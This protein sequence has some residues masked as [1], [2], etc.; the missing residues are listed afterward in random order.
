MEDELRNSLEEEAKSS[1]RSLNA[2][3][4]ARLKDDHTQNQREQGFKEGAYYAAGIL[5]N[6]LRTE[7]NFE[8]DE[9]LK[10]TESIQGLTPPPIDEEGIL[11]FFELQKEGDPDNELPWPPEDVA[12]AVF[13][14]I[15]NPELVEKATTNTKKRNKKPPRFIGDKR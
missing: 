5:A 8:S 13:R 9:C 1:G 2:E 14:F 3:I 7:Y 15:K 11:T 4:C 12:R 10:I 6:I